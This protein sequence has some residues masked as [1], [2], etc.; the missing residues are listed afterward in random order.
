MHYLTLIKTW[1]SLFY[2][3]SV[4]GDSIVSAKENNHSTETNEHKSVL[5]KI[6]IIFFIFSWV[7]KMKACFFFLV[8]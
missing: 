7:I 4:S 1:S 3:V 8:L 2:D 5:C 6:N